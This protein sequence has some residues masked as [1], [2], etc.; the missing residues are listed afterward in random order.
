M[1]QTLYRNIDLVRIPVKA[2]ISEYYFPQNVDWAD[3]KVDKILACIPQTACVDPMDGTTSV[4]TQGDY[5]DIYFNI[6]SADQHELLHAVSAEQLAHI[7]NHPILI[8]SKLDLSLC[9]V[10]FTTAPASDYTLLLY[11]YHDNRVA[12]VE[13]P[14]RSITLDFELA[15][16]Q[17]INL[18]DIITTYIH[19]LPAK[20]KGII[21]WS[22]ISAPAYI[23]LRDYEETYIL[24]NLHSELAR[25]QMNGGYAQTSQ[26]VPMLFDNIDI[27]F[28][29]SHIRNAEGNNNRQ[30]ITLLY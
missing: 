14:R 9:N 13:L 10:Y 11:V 26:V 5:A 24:Q 21:F 22:A 17:D 4:L 8:N 25:S 28:Q 29:Y 6:Y 15:A 18:Q 20:V 19:A 3:C 23:T 2:G 27:D 30:K 1:K 12:D 16:H 7:N